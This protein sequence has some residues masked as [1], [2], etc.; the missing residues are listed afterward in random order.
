MPSVDWRDEAGN[1]RE[2]RRVMLDRQRRYFATRRPVS[3]LPTNTSYVHR[4]LEEVIAAGGLRAGE[5]VSEWGAGVGRFSRLLAAS[6]LEV[7]A[8]ELSPAQADQCRQQLHPWRGATVD[9]GDILDVLGPGVRRFDAV[10]GFFT[11]HHL[12]DLPDYFAA[13]AGC[14]KPGGRLVFTEPNPWNPLF[15]IQIALTPGMRWRE[16]SGIYALWP[17]DVRRMATSAGFRRVRIAYYGALPRAPYNAFARW[18]GERL[19]ERLIPAG[20]KPFQTIV[21]TL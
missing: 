2:A 16:E 6:G 5:S 19:V 15:P 13:A 14:L 4:H 20:L 12:T 10:V 18:G 11:L 7:H 9:V 21:A 17:G 8:I 3:M 1:A